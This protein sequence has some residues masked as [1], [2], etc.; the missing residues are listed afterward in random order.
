MI[1][2]HSVLV[3][4][5]NVSDK[6][7]RENQNTQFMLKNFFLKN[8]HLWS[9]VKKCSRARQATDCDTVHALYM[10]DVI[11]YRHKLRIW[12]TYCFSTGTM[13]MRMLLKCCVFKYVDCLVYDWET[14]SSHKY[15]NT[16]LS[17]TILCTAVQLWE[18]LCL[19]SIRHCFSLHCKQF[20]RSANV[21]YLPRDNF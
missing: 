13:V 1:I 16:H 20:Y 11:G 5:R 12:N 19:Y 21:Y 9:N 14:I 6:I 3:R 8:C 2:S 15:V 4:L 10:L 18:N 7:C 17:R